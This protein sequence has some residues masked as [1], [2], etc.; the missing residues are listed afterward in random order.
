MKHKT[1]A[2]F[3]DWENIKYSA[4]NHLKSLPDIIVL[5]KIARRYGQIAVAR[6]Y[7]NWSDYQHEGDMERFSFQDIDPVFVQTRSFR[8][9]DKAGEKRIVKGSA[10]IKLAC[11]C[12]EL[13]IHSRD[14][15][16]FILA[17]GDGGF[18]HIISKIKSYGKQAVVIGVKATLGKRLG[19]VSEE[20]VYYEDWISS[21]KPGALDQ[22][23]LQVLVEFIRSVEDVRSYKNNNNLQSIKDDM[24][25]KK[26]GFDEEDYGFP[27]FRHL[28]YVA[29]ARNLVK[30]DS[31]SEPAKAYCI[32]ESS[33]DEKIKLFPSAKW[34]NFIQTLEANIAYGKAALIKIIKEN[35]IY[36][37][38]GQ[39]NELLDYAIRSRV[40]WPQSENFFDSKLNKIRT[41]Y[42]Y[43]LNLNH[44][45]VQVYCQS[46]N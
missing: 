38:T 6:A 45:R 1:V 37:E 36:V 4:V 46:L 8:D 3:I 27:T 14:I 20:L 41:V 35:D 2:L 30:I 15:S 18:E 21:L 34:K 12:V 29:E 17:S 31:S 10:D 43:A 9:N 44:P 22:R 25:K 33:S 11:D 26:S 40:L 5:K 23:A 32:D 16:T 42:K 13:L 19:V 7:A 24:R 28:A 39:I